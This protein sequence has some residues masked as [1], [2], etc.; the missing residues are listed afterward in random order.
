MAG[1]PWYFINNLQITAEQKMVTH[2][3]ECEPRLGRAPFLSLRSIPM[4]NATCQRCNCVC[5][6][7]C[8]YTVYQRVALSKYVLN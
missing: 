5:M 8:A 1:P 2:R 7:V 6:Y 4:K 3:T